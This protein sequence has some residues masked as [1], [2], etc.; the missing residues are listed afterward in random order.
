MNLSIQ[1]DDFRYIQSLKPVVET[2]IK[3]SNIDSGELLEQINDSDINNISMTYFKDNTPENQAKFIGVLVGIIQNPDIAEKKDEPEESK[4]DKFPNLT[5]YG[6]KKVNASALTS[7]SQETPTYLI[8]HKD[9]KILF[10]GY[11]DSQPTY[12]GKYLVKLINESGKKSSKAY[13][14]STLGKVDTWI[15]IEKEQYDKVVQKLLPQATATE[16]K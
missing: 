7:A 11:I 14:S 15:L 5:V 10:F 8:K 12:V 16:I 3:A 13:E 9:G 4:P 2:Y 1:D 6:N